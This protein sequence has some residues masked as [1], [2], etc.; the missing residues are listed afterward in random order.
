MAPASAA[1]CQAQCT[2]AR[3]AAVAA[4][5]GAS[6]PRSRSDA[7]GRRPRLRRGGAGD[8]SRR[9]VNSHRA[10]P[11]TPDGGR[12]PP[13]LRQRATAGSTAGVSCRARRLG[14]GRDWRVGGPEPPDSQPPGRAG[15]ARA[16]PPTVRRPSPSRPGE[17]GRRPG[18]P[19]GGRREREARHDRLGRDRRPD[20]PRHRGLRQPGQCRARR[21]GDPVRQH[22]RPSRCPGPGLPHGLLPGPRRSA[23][24][25][26]ATR[27]PARASRLR[28]SPRGSTPCRAPGSPP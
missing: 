25:S 24:V 20:A 26:R 5:G 23:R 1:H 17:R 10:A 18:G 3:P 19:L 2:A 11:A 9:T 16:V 27:W 22:R 4:G 21:R 15:P 14:V 13:A 8:P 12:R 7:T 6:G 28:P